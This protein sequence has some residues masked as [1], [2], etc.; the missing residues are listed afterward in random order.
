MDLAN[1]L[2]LVPPAVA[3]AWLAH[4]LF[5][6]ELAK[7]S[8]GKIISYFIGVLIIFLAIAWIVDSFFIPWVN[9]RLINASNSTDL[10]QSILIIETV[11]DDSFTNT[12][13]G[14]TLVPTPGPTPIIIYVTP[15]PT[16]PGGGGGG[17]AQP[18]T[19]EWPKQHLV[20]P[21]DT[22]SA[23]GQQYGVPYEAIMQANGLTTVTI[24]PGQTLLIPAPTK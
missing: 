12:G 18:T 8:L 23:I 5:R 22:L 9:A 6:K 24:F 4:L 1:L 17:A 10:Q 14:N 19:G 15:V 13:T 2:V 11:I 16:N 20:Q 21:G 3:L 7:E